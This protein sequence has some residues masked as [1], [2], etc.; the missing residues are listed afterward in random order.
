VRKALVDE[1]APDTTLADDGGWIGMT[2]RWVFTDQAAGASQVTFNV[3]SFE[4][5]GA[6]ELHR[7][8]GCE[9]LL[10]ILEGG[11][12]CLTEGGEVP[13]SQGEVCFVPQGEWHGFRNDTDGMTR[14]ICCYGGAGSLQQAG[15]ELL[16]ARS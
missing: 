8:P 12:T 10:Y 16:D 14:V 4:A 11:G 3:T 7:H 13:I 2:V 1:V 15:Y 5:G 6:H 9:E